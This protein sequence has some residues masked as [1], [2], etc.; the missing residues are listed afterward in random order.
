MEVVIVAA[1][2]TAYTIAAVAGLVNCPFYQDY[3]AR[4]AQADPPA[5][6]ETAEAEAETESDALEIVIVTG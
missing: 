4:Q 6:A 1:E 5:V 3:A 2:V